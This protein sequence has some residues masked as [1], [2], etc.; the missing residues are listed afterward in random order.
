AGARPPQRVDDRRLRRAPERTRPR[1]AA[2]EA[3]RVP[4][5]SDAGERRRVPPARAEGRSGAA[6]PVRQSRLSRA[7][8]HVRLLRYGL[9][10]RAGTL[11]RRRTRPARTAG[12]GP[13]PARARRQAR[14]RH[15][16]HPQSTLRTAARRRDHVT[17]GGNRRRE[18]P[19]RRI[20]VTPFE[21][22]PRQA[23]DRG[24]C[25]LARMSSVVRAGLLLV[26][27]VMAA[28][29]S[30][31]QDR[32]PLPIFAADVRGFYAGLGRDPVTAADLGVEPDQLPSRGLGAVVDAHVYPLRGRSF[33]LGIGGELLMARGRAQQV[34]PATG[35]GVGL[36]VRQRIVSMSPQLSL[37]FG[38]R[39][40]WSYL[41]A[42]MGPLSFETYLG[43]DLP[44]EAPPKK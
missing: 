37:N 12:D 20:V 5:G 32:D 34:N 13:S 9:V 27:L 1:R 28:G 35:E 30:F 26:L 7:C 11:A 24:C 6:R 39:D 23:A 14:P 3:E 36:V 10:S 18:G 42:G 29:P 16:G 40:G 8:R 31:A 19:A 22:P 25:T 4:E 44:S 43:D 15:G 38:H 41:T 33:A 21:T 17:R 2:P